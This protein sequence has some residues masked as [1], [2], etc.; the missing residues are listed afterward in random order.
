[1]SGRSGKA[2]RSAPG[3]LSCPI[4]LKIPLDFQGQASIALGRAG[5]PGEEYVTTNDAFAYGESLHC[6]GLRGMTVQQALPVLDRFGV[7]A[8]WRSNDPA[9]DRVDGIDPSTVLDQYV[10]DAVGL[11][12]GKA[13]VWAAPQPL[14]QPDPGTPLAD[15]YARLD[16]GC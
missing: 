9:I 6:S 4:G 14:P 15:Y 11:S 8:V 13:Y 16:R 10:T 12:E 1:M 2:R 7:T 5:Q 3:S